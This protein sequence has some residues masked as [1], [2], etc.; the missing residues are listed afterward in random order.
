MLRKHRDCAVYEIDACGP[1][2][3]LFV[4]YGVGL[5]IVGNV[6][7]VHAYLV[8]AVG[9]RANRK[10][11]V[12]V[13]GVARV[14]GERRYA[15][16]ILSLRHFFL[17][18]SGIDPVGGLLHVLRIFVRQAELRED[19]VHLCGVLSLAAQYV[20]YF[21]SRVHLLV[22]P[23]DYSCH[24]LVAVLSALELAAGDYYVGRQVF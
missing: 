5:H 12:E 1:F 21:A 14:D 8:I 6:G 2:L 23:L 18:D 9:E 4:Y 17:R 13:L 24:G 20:H 10:R 3:R 19:C 11:V 7:Y 22:A 15:T 16:E